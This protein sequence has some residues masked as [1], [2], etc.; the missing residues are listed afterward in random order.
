MIRKPE[1][2]DFAQPRIRVLHYTWIAFFITFYLW[3]NMA[4]L[5]TTMLKSVDWLTPDH[6]KLL[7]ICNV[8]LTIPA[9]IFIG[10]LI[11]RFGP[12]ITFSGLLIVM[13][14]PAFFFAFGNSFTQLL[15]ARLLL[16]SIGAGFVIGIRMTA[17]WFPPKMVGRAE[18]FYA[19]WGNFGSA[20]AAMTLP[21]IA[22]EVFGGYEDGWRYALAVNGLVALLYGFLYYWLVTDTP[23]GRK[24]VGVRKTQPMLLSTW[25]D[26]IQYLVW[27][28]PL[29]AALGLLAWRMSTIKIG[30]GDEGAFISQQTLYIVWGVLTL[31]YVAHAAKTL[32]VNLPHLRKGVR[33]DDRF[34]FNDV[35]AL[36]TTYFANFGAE[37]AV[38]SMLP[39]FFESTFT[40]T[41]TMAGIFAS[42]FAFVNLFARP[43]GGLVS[44]M[45]GSRKRIMLVYMLGITLGFFGM[46]FI[47]SSWPIWAAVALT[48]ACSFFVQGAEGATFAIIPFIKHRF[49]GQIA[50]MAGAYGNVGAVVY[51]IVYSMVDA[52][53]FFYI[54][55]GGAA[56][57][58]VYC[59]VFLKEPE[60]SFAD[61]FDT[62]VPAHATEQ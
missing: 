54:L 30:N 15:V 6:L 47:E 58:L 44:D 59:L 21:W 60:G 46:G 62:G 3:F 18:G 41:P 39:A 27:S 17:E 8:A 2:I 36:N 40:I 20:W 37:L 34:S 12:R 32:Q 53:T 48:V 1:I 16:S 4:P 13:S 10:A 14:F 29:M 50:G 11:D 31:V 23:A 61:E 43:L 42:S 52:R 28:V 45:M 33:K 51:L 5:A 57:S 49:T 55:A 22:L 26:L 24:Y 38:V 7:A 56:F 35:A 9:R 25:G 19:G